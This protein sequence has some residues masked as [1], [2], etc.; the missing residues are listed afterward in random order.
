MWVW[1]IWELYYFYN[2]S[3]DLSCFTH[4]GLFL[5]R[6]EPVAVLGWQESEHPSPSWPLVLAQDDTFVDSHQKVKRE[7]QS[8]VK[9]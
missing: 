2:N 6:W 3:V 5:Q 1:D 9:G 8:Q 7:L 4:L